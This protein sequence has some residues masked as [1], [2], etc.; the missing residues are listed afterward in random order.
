MAALFG[1][2]AGRSQS[3]NLVEFRAGKMV[4][5]G[6]MVHPDKRKG[7]VYVH[8]SDDALMHFCWKDRSSG[9]VEEDLI[10]FPDDVEFRHV[11]QCTTGRVY[12]LKFKSSQRRLFFWMQEPKSDR[13]SEYC[14]K[15]ND[16]LNN[17][18]TPGASRGTGLSSDLSGLGSRGRGQESQIM[19]R[20]LTN[21]IDGDSDLQSMLAGMSQQ[22]LMQLMGG[23]GMGGPGSNLSSLMGRPTSAQS[24]ASEPPLRATS[25]SGNRSSAEATPSPRPMTSAGLLN[26]AAGTATAATTTTTTTS[27]TTTSSSAR[28]PGSG[29]TGAQAT[30]L[31]PSRQQQIQL[32]DLQNILSTMNVPTGEQKEAVDLA[33]A[34]NPEAMLPIL[35]NPEV[36]RRLL[37]FLPD[38]QSLP[39]TEHELRST[40]SSPQ[41]QQALT[42]FSQALQ[43]GQLGPLMNQFG[44]GED[45]ANA[46]AQGDMEAFVK[47]L[48][49]AMKKKDE[50]KGKGEEKMD[51]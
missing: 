42:S 35:S 22:Q 41:F 31:P 6:K 12:V 24:T 15:V 49:E 7:Q 40:M 8:Q 18:P 1:N 13:D 16:N 48:Q 4:M 43:S 20:F 34:L 27:T 25:A 26:P 10:I 36:Q 44:L 32:S 11:P 14:K 29:A 38:S 19:D 46:A 30:G 3:K 23:M 17:P 45:V 33:K 37:P 51:H 28:A 9:T 5:K 21:L 50:E 39:R 2:T 47:A